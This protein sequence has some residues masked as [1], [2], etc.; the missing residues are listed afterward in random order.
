MGAVWTQHVLYRNPESTHPVTRWSHYILRYRTK[1]RLRRPL[2]WDHATGEGS[3]NLI[4]FLIT[5]LSQPTLALLDY[6]Q[7]IQDK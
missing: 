5:R 7:Y 1:I 3:I 6:F 4:T 2:R